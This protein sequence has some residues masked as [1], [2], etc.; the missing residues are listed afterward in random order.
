MVGYAFRIRIVLMLCMLVFTVV[1]TSAQVSDDA[2]LKLSTP[3]V[4]GSHVAELQQFLIDQGYDVGEDGA[5]GWFGPN[6]ETALKQYQT[7]MGMAATGRVTWGVARD[8]LFAFFTGHF[9]EKTL[10]FNF[11]N[12]MLYS[13]LNNPLEKAGVKRFLGWDSD[14]GREFGWEEDFYPVGKVHISGHVFL[15]LFSHSQGPVEEEDAS[16]YPEEI[17]ECRLYSL[18]TSSNVADHFVLFM[19]SLPDGAERMSDW[20]EWMYTEVYVHETFVEI[21][22]EIQGYARDPE[23]VDGTRWKVRIMPDG[24]FSEE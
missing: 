5:D 11:N 15:I 10:P 12:E 2:V 23:S 14:A 24:T 1:F 18:D 16:S 19:D 8:W 13:K 17:F 7:A 9:Q 21:F 22:E 3:R 20:Y 6:T 4:N